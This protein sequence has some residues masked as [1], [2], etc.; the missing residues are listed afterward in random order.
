MSQDAK[1]H[2]LLYFG[3]DV[4]VA[5]Q[6]GF[7]DMY[8]AVTKTYGPK[9]TNVQIEKTYGR[10]V[11][12]RDGVTVAREVYSSVRQN[13]MAMQ[14][15]HEASDT[16]NRVA[17]DGTTA[18]VALTYWLYK[19]ASEKVAAGRN[20]MDLKAEIMDG[21]Y[22]VLDKLSSMS[23]SV[24]KGQLIQVAT[25]SSGDEALGQLIAEAVEHIGPDGGIITEKAPIT[26]VSR[27]YVDGYYLQS[28]FQAIE[29][30]KKTL[31]NPY[32]IVT[33]KPIASG[34]D[35]IELIQKVAE[36]AHIDQGIVDQNGK[37]ILNQPLNH[38]LR[39]AIFG[40][41]E[42]D[43]YNT[44]VAN[45]QKGVF[46]GVIVKTPPMGEIGHQYLDDLAV[47]TGGKSI[48]PGENMANVNASYVGKAGK[49]TCTA[50]DTVVFD[51]EHADEDLKQRLSELKD[52]IATETID[53]IAE[54]HRDRLAKLENKVARFQIGGA[55]D[56]ER[57]EKE[58]R[59][60]DAIQATRAAAAF[61]VVAGGGVALVELS[62]IPGLSD[63]W[64]KA[65]R[66]TFQ[67]LLKNAN[68]PAEVKLNEILKSKYPMGY[69]LKATGN[70]VDIIEA[71]I[72]DPTLVI[73]QVVTNAASTAANAITTDTQIT[74]QNRKE[75][76]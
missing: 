70:L 58:F 40:D 46:D 21:S 27:E 7:K 56:T 34:L 39:I 45:I 35:A 64:V 9:G 6:Q 19:V 36:A 62:R 25:V 48:K 60:E 2:K 20:R 69:N 59:I 1:D 10:P 42:G 41:I 44:I 13:N 54:K 72:L 15:M 57:E 50:N 11:L 30:G 73:E 23:K 43:A 47:Y 75:D 29:L 63:I 33:A 17:G 49:V 5:M 16:T 8:K 66:S 61:G 68:L 31:E 65:L 4:Q 74:F 53:Q 67:R 18:T 28:G 22:K 32:I 52:K 14:M 26:D 71:G 51:G 55:T 12:T 24:K 37:A 76:D 3:K 38:P